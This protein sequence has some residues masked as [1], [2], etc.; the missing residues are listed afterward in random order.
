MNEKYE[1]ENEFEDEIDMENSENEKNIVVLNEE[2]GS[3]ID[4][5]LSEKARVDTD[6]YSTAYKR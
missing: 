1:A 5:F 4:K 3:R 2:A 6:T